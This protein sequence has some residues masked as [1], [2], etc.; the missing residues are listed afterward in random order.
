MMYFIENPTPSIQQKLH[1]HATERIE[2]H[3]SKSGNTL[4]L[5][6][7]GGKNDAYPPV[8]RSG[9]TDVFSNEGSKEIGVAG[10]HPW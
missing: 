6:C 3:I 2:N 4:D 9:K 1:L 8:R 10:I 5:E 7:F